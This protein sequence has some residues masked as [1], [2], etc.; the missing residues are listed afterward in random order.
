MSKPRLFIG[1]SSEAVDLAYSVQGN[2]EKDA[3]VTVWPQG[4]FQLSISAV[5]S[6]RNDADTFDFALFVFSPDDIV[7]IRDQS[8]P[9]VRD[10]VIFEL[11]LFVGVLGRE[12]CFMLAPKAEFRMPTDLIGMTTATYDTNR[13]DD[14]LEAATGRACNQIRQSIR[15]SGY[16]VGRAS[17]SASATNEAQSEGIGSAEAGKEEVVKE[18]EDRRWDW[19]EPY[20]AEQFADAVPLI[21]KELEQV[22]EPDDKLFL[23]AFR[24]SALAGI[25]L[26]N[27]ANAF[28]QIIND[29]PAYD[30]NYLLYAQA[31][32]KRSNRWDESLTILGRGLTVGTFIGD[33]AAE[34]IEVLRELGRGNEVTQMLRDCAV[35][36]PKEAKLYLLLAEEYVRVKE[37]ENALGALEQI[38]SDLADDSSI[39]E[40][41]AL[42]LSEGADPTLALPVYRKLVHR[43]PKSWI[44]LTRRA[45]IYLTLGLFDLAFF[46]YKKADTLADSQEGWIQGNIGN[47]L[48]RRG[49]FREA[50]SY[51]QKAVELANSDFSHDRIAEAMRE[52]DK[53]EKQAREICD[54]AREKLATAR[55]AR[56]AGATPTAES[57]AV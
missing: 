4:I 56:A 9:A 20:T 10:N 45:N 7:S 41:Y 49:L 57:S 40:R 2:L 36:R 48:I 50:I 8:K 11:G 47:M 27:G 54:Q 52:R 24:A 18:K 44:Y 43:Y 21:E 28:E 30:L 25:S 31:C 39:L 6:L 17:P 34:K 37:T 53:E 16:R 12:R 3:E 46:E 35:K 19:V 55:N 1:S 29:S 15:R 5:E 26:R 51:L 22:V 13:S 38:P 23:S 42:L 33:L 32:G 14:N